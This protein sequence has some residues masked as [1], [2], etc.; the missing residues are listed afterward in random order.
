MPY[1]K[2]SVCFC[3][4]TPRPAKGSSL[5]LKRIYM[6]IIISCFNRAPNDGGVI[7]SWAH[8]LPLGSEQLYFCINFTVQ[9][10]PDVFGPYE[11]KQS[12]DLHQFSLTNFVYCEV[13]FLV[14]TREFF[15]FTSS[16]LELTKFNQGKW[17]IIKWTFSNL[18]TLRECVRNLDQRVQKVMS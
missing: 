16:H 11:I 9:G 6:S 8:A 5:P 14:V 2:N 4:F 1:T 15:Y 17:F 3:L 10:W 12:A 7:C 13:W 18:C